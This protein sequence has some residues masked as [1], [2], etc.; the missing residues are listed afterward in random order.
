[1][2]VS[3]TWDAGTQLIYLK[4]TDDKETWGCSSMARC[5]LSCLGGQGWASVLTNLEGTTA[6][7]Q[8]CLVENDGQDC[9]KVMTVLSTKSV[10]DCL[11]CQIH[12]SIFIL[13]CLLKAALKEPRDLPS[14]QRFSFPFPFPFL[15]DRF[16]LH[17]PGWPRIY[18]VAQHGLEIHFRP[19]ASAS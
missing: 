9:C 15:K 13:P 17:S 6:A 16:S 11:V 3:V 8:S 5:W 7:G 2:S 12:V 10:G 1:M 18:Y 4:E 14:A 19:V